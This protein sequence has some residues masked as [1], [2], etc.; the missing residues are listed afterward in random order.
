M[1]LCCC[2]ICERAHLESIDSVSQFGTQGAGPREEIQ[3]REED[4]EL[5][6]IDNFP[7]MED[8]GSIYVVKRKDDRSE[9][10]SSYI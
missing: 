8:E 5:K 9:S 4:D 10:S 7:T 3:K 6:W 2:D 1:R